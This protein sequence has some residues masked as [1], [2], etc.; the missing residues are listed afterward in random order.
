MGLE[1]RQVGTAHRLGHGKLEQSMHQK[2]GKNVA[3]R[4]PGAVVYTKELTDFNPE[5][6]PF[7]NDVNGTNMAINAGFSGVAALIYSSG[8]ANADSG[9]SDADTASK[10]IDAA[11]GQ[12]FVTTVS[13]GMVVR[14]TQPATDTFAHVT[15]IDDN[16][17]LSLDADIFGSQPET[18]TVGAEW[19]GTA[20]TGSWNFTTDISL[21]DGDNGDEARFDNAF[22]SVMSNYTAV[23]GKITL[24]TWNEINNSLLLSFSL[25]GVLQGNAVDL[26]DYID[27]GLLGTQQNFVIPKADLGLSTQTVDDMN[28]FL[29]RT[30]GPKVVVDLDDIQL[31]KAG[32]SIVYK[33]T[34]PKGTLFHINELRL[35]LADN[36]TGIVANG[37][38]H[39]LAY[40]DFMGITSP[41]SNGIVFQRVQNGE[42]NFSVTINQLGDFLATGSNIVNAISDG[43]NTFITLLI[44]FPKPI[45]LNGNKDDFL[46]FTVNDDLS[47]LLQFTAAARGALEV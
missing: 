4:L 30:G 11:P 20:V 7:L 28:L 43:T 40:D 25:A 18:Y 29:V 23:T 17:T 9:T 14:N 45:I 19:P 46:S 35:G 21:T 15:A 16:D 10:L 41:L 32:G 38:M 6:H 1:V 13:V 3:E 8:S 42:V 26:N 44:E 2:A 27:T 5:F 37:T 34:T 47:G 22:T 33:A 39:G 12:N 31:E 24:T 36:I